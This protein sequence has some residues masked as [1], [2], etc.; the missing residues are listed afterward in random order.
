[1]C[2]LA[3]NL[4]RNR[5][6]EEASN[7]LVS[8]KTYYSNVHNIKNWASFEFYYRKAQLMNKQ[9]RIRECEE[10]LRSLLQNYNECV[11]A[12]DI[13]NAKEFLARVLKSTGCLLEAET[14]YRKAFY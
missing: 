1:M 13:H 2:E 6:L 3:W 12:L 14:R 11:S 5:K 7:V 4:V 8:V 9:N 10:I